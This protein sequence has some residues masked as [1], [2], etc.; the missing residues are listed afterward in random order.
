MNKKNLISASLLALLATILT[1]GIALAHTTVTV[2]NY[3]IEVGWTDEPPVVGQRNAVVI[4]V[5]DTT[6]AEKEV[7]ISK[8]VVNVSYGGQTKALT[9][10][11]LSEDAR[12]Q[13]IAPIL[14]TIPG[15]YTVQLRGQ[16]G[17]GMN[18]NLDVQPEEV[19]AADTLAFPNQSG[20][21]SQRGGIEMTTW[22]SGGALLV[23]L[24]ALGMGVAA[25]RRSR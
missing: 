12:N 9:L 22:L 5:S 20:S 17:D 21:Q 18:V 13:Y 14:P 6:D 3:E 19:A 11:P 8:L 1:F 10:Q 15:Q 16:I 25:L 4:N 23:A 24:A 2:G 7:D